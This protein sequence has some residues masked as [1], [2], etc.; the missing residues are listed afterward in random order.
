[1]NHSW[2]AYDLALSWHHNLIGCLARI[3]RST[4]AGAQGRAR[5]GRLSQDSKGGTDLI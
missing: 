2:T 5:T 3:D 4:P 1:M